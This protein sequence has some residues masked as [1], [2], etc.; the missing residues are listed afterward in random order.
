MLIVLII[1]EVLGVNFGEVYRGMF[2]SR[3][4]FLNACNNEIKAKVEGT[5]FKESHILKILS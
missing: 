4:D 3:C 1:I 2:Q 5:E